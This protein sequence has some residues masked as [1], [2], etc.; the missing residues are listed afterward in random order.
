MPSLEDPPDPLALGR[1][2]LTH[3]QVALAVA[4]WRRVAEQHPDNL[5]AWACL[6]YAMSLDPCG[7]PEAYLQEATRHGLRLTQRAQHS[8]LAPFTEWRLPYAPSDDAPLRVGLVSG[9]FHEHPVGYFLEG[10]LQATP[11]QRVQWFAYANRDHGDALT[12]RLQASVTHWEPIAHLDDP[13]VARKIHAHGLHVLIDL[14]G[15]TD[16]NRL[17]VFA[18]QAAPVQVSWLGH[19]ASTGLPTMDA[20]LAD[21]VSLPMS[22]PAE[23]AF[24]E[25]IERLPDT[26]LCF[27]APTQ[28]P[29]V[30][31]LPALRKGHITFA[32]FQ[33][34]TKFNPAVWQLWARVLNQVPGARLRLASRQTITDTGVAQLTRQLL[35][36][37]LSPSRVDLAHPSERA[38]YLAAYAEVDLVL[39]TFPA[40][41]G[42]TTC[43]ALWMGVPTLTLCDASPTGQ[44]MMRRQGASLLQAAGLHDWV[45]HDEADFVRLAVAKSAEVS[46]L[47]Q[48]R[49]RLR[50]QVQ[51]S[52][53]MDAP[54][55][56][57][58]L[59]AALRRTWDRKWGASGSQ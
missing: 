55:F 42:T 39:D 4:E 3:G 34:A 20:V 33:S 7:T 43:E 16:G 46:A 47:A 36:A 22:W 51:R 24:C 13:T 54:R 59:D 49:Q 37:G 19:W 32:S 23:L 48:L 50:A 6:L 58:A 41:G 8:T 53:L 2:L 31:A 9:N 45:A 15:Y 21:P 10:V 5:S 14:D 56:A 57:T 28:A 11:T 35:D 52:P 29:D 1:H 17:P 40:T 12:A 26:R 44:P 30:S 27:S 25:A 18:W 38:Q